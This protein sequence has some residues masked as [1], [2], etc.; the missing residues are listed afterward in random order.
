MTGI[1]NEGSPYSSWYMAEEAESWGRKLIYLAGSVEVDAKI[2][3]QEIP[4]YLILSD[5][6]G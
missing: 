5:P 3:P 4:S 2:L 1:G 6:N